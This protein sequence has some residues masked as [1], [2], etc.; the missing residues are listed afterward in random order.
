MSRLIYICVPSIFY[1]MINRGSYTSAHALLNLFNKSRNS[2][3]MRGLLSISSLFYK[4]LNEYNKT[5]ARMLSH[6]IKITSKLHFFRLNCH[7]FVINYAA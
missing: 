6:D 2:S 4:D 3:K 5:R 1:G 7:D